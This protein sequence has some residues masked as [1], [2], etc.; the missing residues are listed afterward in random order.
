[1]QCPFVQLTDKDLLLRNVSIEQCFSSHSNEVRQNSST[2]AF[3]TISLYDEN[4]GLMTM[5][6]MK[7]FHSLIVLSRTHC[8]NTARIRS[9]R[10]L[11]IGAPFA[12][13]CCW[14]LL[15]NQDT[16]YLTC[17]SL[18]R[19]WKIYGAMIQNPF[20]LRLF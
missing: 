4:H 9:P 3:E 10:C 18:T 11:D 6:N 14:K 19:S 15:K 17:R 2:L 16:Q 20:V 1:M 12:G 7:N 13:N 8:S 5:L